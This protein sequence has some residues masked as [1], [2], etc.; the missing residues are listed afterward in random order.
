MVELVMLVPHE[1]QSSNPESA[2]SNAV[3]QTENHHL[4][5]SKIED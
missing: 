5:G 3:L 2:K 4:K 1:V